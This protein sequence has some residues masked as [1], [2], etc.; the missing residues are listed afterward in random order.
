MRASL[1]IGYHTLVKAF[2][3]AVYALARRSSSYCGITSFVEIRIG[4]IIQDE[5]VLF[6]GAFSGV[7]DRIVSLSNPTS[8][9]SE[10]KMV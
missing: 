2:S 4:I 7:H 1:R 3:P 9:S 5:I 6:K 8:Q 10:Y